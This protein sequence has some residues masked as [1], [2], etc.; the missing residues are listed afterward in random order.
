MPVT[1]ALHRKDMQN[2]HDVMRADRER[3]SL[4]TDVF[5]VA[6]LEDG[7]RRGGHQGIAS[8]VDVIPEQTAAA[9]CSRIVCYIIY[10]ELIK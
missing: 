8:V 6:S 9:W 1:N 4:G 2:L 10:S 7:C 5:H 3:V